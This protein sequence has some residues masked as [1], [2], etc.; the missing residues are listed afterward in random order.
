MIIEK[1]SGFWGGNM[2]FEVI[3]AVCARAGAVG[4]WKSRRFCGPRRIA[5]LRAVGRVQAARRAGV[6]DIALTPPAKL[7]PSLSKNLSCG[8]AASH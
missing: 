5:A 2:N 7:G 1:V 4:K 8:G 6:R 3:P